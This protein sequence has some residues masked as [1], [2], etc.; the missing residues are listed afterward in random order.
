MGWSIVARGLAL[1]AIA[2][3]AC[4]SGKPV[5]RDTPIENRRSVTSEEPRPATQTPYWC[6]ISDGGFEYPEM[7]CA[8]RR[9]GHAEILAK[10]AGSQRFRGTITRRGD[11]FLFTGELYC[12]WGDCEKSLRGTFEPVGNGALRGTFDN[13]SMVVTLVPAPA[14]S[15]WGGAS[16]GGDS[17]G[18]LGHTRPR[19]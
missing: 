10:L 2:T 6:S 5:P 13:D 17:Y 9:E 8:I 3:V 12:P 16:Y 14:D 1:A 11:G 4:W 19:R 7:P 15:A 18:G